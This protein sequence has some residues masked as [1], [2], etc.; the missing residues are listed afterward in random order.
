LSISA[1]CGVGELRSVGV[2]ASEEAAIKEARSALAMQIQS[3]IKVSRK[4]VESQQILGGKENLSSNY[5][6][7]TVIEATLLNAQAARINSI[8]RGKGEV[9]AVLCM[10]RSDAAK[11]FIEKQRPVADS[12]MFAANAALGT[13][14]PKQKSEAFQRAHGL[15]NEL[16]KLQG[17]VESMGAGEEDFFVKSSEIYS[18]ARDDYKDY[19]RN[20]KVYW[21]DSDSECSKAAFSVLSGKIKMEKAECQGKDGFK[22]KFAC[23]DE[24]C[25]SSSFGGVEC[26]I[27]PSL[28]VEAC[29]GES[30]Y[31]LKVSELPK[32]RD[33]HSVSRAKGNLLEKLPSANFF[34]EWEK[35]LKGWIPLCA[36]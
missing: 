31:L 5:E 20:Q 12:L 6:S 15:W 35:E 16:A 29:S 21:E 14:H 23:P 11:G 17:V 4:H 18:K 3:S 19:C 33:M 2:G 24:K 13:K 22:L 7:E 30:Y 32:G 10:S 8:E 9:G 1:E 26:S 25:V 34:N 27:D 36:N 28:S